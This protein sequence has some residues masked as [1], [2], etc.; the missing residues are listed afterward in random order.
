MER[1]GNQGWLE[2]LQIFLRNLRRLWSTSARFCWRGRWDSC[3]D[4]SVIELGENSSFQEQPDPMP[5]LK[6]SPRSDLTRKKPHLQPEESSLCMSEKSSFTQAEKTHLLPK[7]KVGELTSH[8]TGGAYHICSRD[9]QSC[10]LGNHLSREEE[11][12]SARQ[13]GNSA[14]WG[15][16][17]RVILTWSP[18]SFYQDTFPFS[19]I[20]QN[21]V[22]RASAELYKY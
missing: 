5:I 4:R 22:W 1:D 21:E 19:I 14:K 8:A 9:M 15:C 13:S 12:A 17:E 20:C 11:N 16:A 7:I 18:I 6:S 2:T 3:V 10:A